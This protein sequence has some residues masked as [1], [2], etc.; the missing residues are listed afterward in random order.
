MSLIVSTVGTKRL[1]DVWR[2]DFYSKALVHGVARHPESNVWERSETSC[3]LWGEM[4]HF[5]QHDDLCGIGK[6]NLGWV[7][8]TIHEIVLYPAEQTV[9]GG[10]GLVGLKI[11]NM[12]VAKN[13]IGRLAVPKMKTGFVFYTVR[14]V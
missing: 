11:I 13:H 10:I 12:A 1:I 7:L 4:L 8:F 9:A 3:C 6:A 14:S 5:V 2:N